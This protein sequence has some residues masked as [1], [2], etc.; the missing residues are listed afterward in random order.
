M[1]VL[2]RMQIPCWFPVANFPFIP[3]LEAVG[4]VFV[5][6]DN[7]RSRLASVVVVITCDVYL[8]K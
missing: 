5:V 7:D 1:T 2:S 8:E 4:T 3:W 6:A